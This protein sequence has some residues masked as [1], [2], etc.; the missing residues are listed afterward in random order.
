LKQLRFD[1]QPFVQRSALAVR[2]VEIGCS[3]AGCR[4][5]G[6]GPPRAKLRTAR[7]QGQGFPLSNNL[8]DRPR[9]FSASL[10]V[11]H[12]PGMDQV[13]RAGSVPEDGW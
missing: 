2:A 3:R 8:V 1:A 10:G 9:A 12:R 7:P 6:D 11:D 5:C 4:E 13:D